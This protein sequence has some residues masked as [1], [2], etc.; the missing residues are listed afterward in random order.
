MSYHPKYLEQFECIAPLDNSWNKIIFSNTCRIEHDIHNM[1]LSLK[2]VHQGAEIYEIDGKV[3][4]VK[5]GQ[6]LLVNHN[7]RAHVS[8]DSKNLPVIGTCLYIDPD[9]LHEIICTQRQS[10]SEN[11]DNSTSKINALE[12]LEAVY[13]IGESPKVSQLLQRIS[14]YRQRQL[15]DEEQR[16]LYWTIAEVLVQHGEKTQQQIQDIASEKRSTREELYRRLLIAIDFMQ[17]NFDRKIAVRDIASAACLSEYHFMRTFRQ[18]FGKTPNQYL[19]QL[20]LQRAANLL[21]QQQHSITE[22]A[23]LCGF[24][25]VQYFSK[26]FKKAYQQ[27]PSEY[28]RRHQ[29]LTLSAF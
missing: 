25:D 6:F 18:S 26:S 4:D 21:R 20:R 10:L 2:Y 14:Q 3:Y 7:R 28:Q 27:S 11:L 8:I 22:I 17:N 1:G 24:S 5:A 9:L 19:S 23:T 15:S 13:H 29:P 16:E 12:Y